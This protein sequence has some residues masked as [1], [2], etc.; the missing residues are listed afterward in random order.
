MPTAI[1]QPDVRPPAVAGMFY[2][3]NPAALQQTVRDALR[4]AEAHVRPDE[5]AP[6]ALIAPH[7]GYL[8]SG[9]IA[10]SAYA[11]LARARH[12]IR[13]VVLV[14]PAH[15]VSFFGI[16]ASTAAAF[17]TPLGEVPVDRRA[18]AALAGTRGNAPA[19]ACPRLLLCLMSAL[20]AL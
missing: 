2:P 15:R 11:R 16:A 10:A 18:F 19:L 6:R 8:Y 5:P 3:G 7:A 20:T 14:G 12:T 17:A 4:Q 13:R 9:A 1:P